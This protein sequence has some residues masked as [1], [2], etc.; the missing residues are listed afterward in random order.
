MATGLE[1][2]DEQLNYFRICFIT[3][4]VIT[5]G[6]RTIFKQEWDN[7]YKATLGEWEDEP[8]N[9]LD[10]KNQES[11]RNQ[12]RNARLLA[13]M[14]NGNRAEWDC[15]MLFYAILYSDCIG[16]GLNAVV[17][18]NVDDLRNFRNKGPAHF[19]HGRVNETEFQTAVD[20][21]IVAF[22]ALGLSDLKIQET[23]NQKS[24]PTDELKDKE[25]ELGEKCETLK[26]TEKHRKVLEE[27]LLT[28]AP[29]AFC[30]LPPKPSHDVAERDHEL[31]KIAQQLK[32]LK[33]TNESRLTSLYIS[34]NPGSGK[35]QLAGLAA[36]KFFDDKKQI[37]GNNTFVMTLN[38]QSFD[39]LLESYVSFARHLKCSEYAVTNTVTKK[40]LKTEGKIAN[41]KSLIGTKVKLY[42]SW[43]L[44]VDNVVSLSGMNPHLP[45]TGDTHWCKG[46]LLIT[47]QDTAGIPSETSFSNHISVSKGM[48]PSDAISLLASLSGIADG[49]TEKEVA[50]ALDYQPLAL[51]SAAIFAKQVRE[52]SSNFGWKGYLE[53][54]DSGERSNTEAFL[55]VTNQ[56]Y[57]ITMTT[58]ISLAVDEAMSSDK[59]LNQ[60]F[61]FISLCSQQPLNLDLVIKYIL[62]VENESDRSGLDES[63]DKDII[64]LRI[65]K[66][67]LLLVKE[68]ES[69]VYI[70][71]H[72]IVR[73]V[74]QTRIKKYSKAQYFQII[75]WGITSFNQFID[76]NDLD[77]EDSISNSFQLVPHFKCLI[78]EIESVLNVADLSEVNLSVK[79]YP[80]YFGKFSNICANH[81]EFNSAKTI[82]NIA[83]KLIQQGGVFC[84]GV[85]AAVY[86]ELG[87][88]HHRMGDLEQAK[89]YHDRALAI[90]IEK[91]GSQHID[92]ASSYNNIATL[93]RDQGD[94]EQAKEY[95]DRALA[96][97]IEK[98]GSEHIDVASSYNNIASVLRAQGDLGQA[99]AYH[100]RALA[101]RIEK[102]GSQHIDVASSY[103]NIASVLHDQGD[104]EQAKEYHDRALAIWIEKLGSQH[105]DVASSYN[106]IATV[107]HDQGDL[108][109]AKE[110][111]DRA[112]AIWIEKLGS[113]HIDVASSYNNI[114]TVLHDQGDLEQAKEYH[115]RAL[116]IR[117]EKLG[118]QHIDVATSYNNIATVL[119]DQG[120]LEQAKEYLDR[121]LA[122]RIE[123]LGS[124]HIDVA[125]S[126]NNIAS[127]LHDQGDLEQAKEYHDRAL[128]I[129]IEKLGSQHIDVAT[130]YNNIATVLHDQGDLEQ[131]KEY[132]DRALAIRIEKLGSQHI[133][134]A[135][136]YN[137]IASV[138]H[139]QGDLEQA[140]EYHDRALAIW[141]EK[142]GSQHIDVATSYNNIATVLHDQGDLEQAKEYH[143]RALAIWIEKL[144][145]Q[146]IDVA[147]SYNNIATVLHDQGDL[148]QAKKYHDRALAIRIEKLGSQH[149]DV[150]TSYNN[151]ATVLH[152]QGD[153]EQAKEYLDRALAIR[154]EKLGSE[155]I[156]TASSYNNIASVLRAQGDLGQAKAYRELA[157][158]IRIQKLGSQHIRVADSYKNLAV[159]L[160][161]HGELE[162]AKDYF[163]RALSIYLIRLGPGHSNVTTV[164]RHLARLQKLSSRVKRLN[165]VIY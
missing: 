114:A 98:L 163:E 155:H 136:S 66:S 113:Q 6:L 24:F 86:N 39:S 64:G 18:L 72:Q 118:S 134:V 96:I 8:R 139:D 14:V 153:L 20:K 97:R 48:T 128:A 54:L 71:V 45:E 135:T 91:L 142:L 55:A 63:A 87:H 73:N 2:T 32:Q 162:Q 37:A 3:T 127:V 130:S 112:L 101:I 123:K 25:Q 38:A 17:Q 161:D 90:R 83:L 59:V 49:E 111:H 125:S 40:N 43:L 81:C 115:D 28:E 126:Y 51:A 50:R 160:R 104:L 165:C 23:R 145:S 121:A 53:K 11:P 159:V 88:I 129:R 143:D 117:I 109:Q 146:H 133:D 103:N 122:I 12:N 140:K 33:E 27:Q 61:S 92:V 42:S 80:I 147:S 156:D 74:T 15:T 95:L 105:I 56:S 119:H 76:E 148:E 94:L 141:I 157:L 19:P 10:F 149:I 132:H 30:I 4:D 57:P 158:A 78:T 93:L 58:A 29:A 124:Q 84:E 150:A 107:L 106:N 34:G 138:L 108:E 82:C 120:D 41:M 5:E 99:K 79:H 21:V 62:N 60:A 36:K 116:A 9:G 13:T 1:Y 46:Q 22:Q 52:A 85:F 69:G 68:D 151:I 67:S 77:E 16:P 102:L 164:Q 7:R 31:A 154:I 152:D 131:A 75:H 26:E 89:E 137:N 47:S 35:S 44:V 100:N 110:Y 70:Q 144:G 65:R